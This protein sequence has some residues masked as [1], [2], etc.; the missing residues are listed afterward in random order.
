VGLDIELPTVIRSIGWRKLYD[1]PH[2]GSH[3]LT[4]EFLMTFETYVHDGN[5][6][7]CCYLY[8]E[9]YRFVFPHFSE[10]MD[11][12]RSCLPESQAMRNFNHLD[13]CNDISGKTAR[14]RFIDI[15]NPS[16]KFLHRWL[17][18]TLFSMRELCS[19]TITELKCLFSMVHRIKYTP[20]ADIV[21]YFKE[22]HTL[23]GPIECTS[24]VTRIA[25]NIRCPEM[26]NVAY[27][28]GGVL[29]LGLSHFVHTHVL[30]EELD[31]SISMLYEGGNKMLR[32]PNQ[33]YLLC[34]CDQ[35]IVQL[36]TLEN[37]HRSISGPPRT[38]WRAP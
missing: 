20:I 18:F 29:I 35:L 28:E 33:A 2:S 27:I 21:D 12:S 38:H 16:L 24:L 7:V 37:M 4:L 9:T 36:N 8:G 17:S 34:S 23:S 10:L 6:W 14:I 13:F 19:V 31:H 30:R 22:I 26:H 32:L 5:P 1:E 25:L 11:F 15:Q 3:I